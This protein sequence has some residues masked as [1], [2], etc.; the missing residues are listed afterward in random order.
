MLASSENALQELQYQ[1]DQLNTEDFCL[2][3]FTALT[4]LKILL[5]GLFLLLVHAI[6]RSAQLTDRAA[7]KA[8]NSQAWLNGKQIQATFSG[9]Q[10]CTRSTG[11]CA[12]PQK[13]AANSKK[14]DLQSLRCRQQVLKDESG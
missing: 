10:S 12:W 3:D 4:W 14:Q 9:K 6:L 2:Q 7:A 11:C 8:R 13:L 1:A 5:T